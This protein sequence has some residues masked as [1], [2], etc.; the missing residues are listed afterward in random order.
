MYDMAQQKSYR[1]VGI[2]CWGVVGGVVVDVSI[3]MMIIG[4]LAGYIII[5]AQALLP[6]SSFIPSHYLP[7]LLVCLGCCS[8]C[9]C[10]SAV[11]PL[12]LSLLA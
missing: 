6:I 10:C 12:F 3:V 7:M 1:N 5:T 4:A 2:R 9:S 11:Q 8:C